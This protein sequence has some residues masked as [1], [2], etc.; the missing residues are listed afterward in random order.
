MFKSTP[1]NKALAQKIFNDIVNLYKKHKFARV[2]ENV[3][4]NQDFLGGFLSMREQQSLNLMYSDCIY[5][6]IMSASKDND[7]DKLDYMLNIYAP[8]L[9]VHLPDKKRTEI[10]FLKEK[11]KISVLKNSAKDPNVN[12]NTKL[13]MSGVSLPSPS[14]S[15]RVINKRFVIGVIVVILILFAVFFTVRF[16][17]NK[18]NSD[19][20]GKT[21][22]VQR[23]ITSP[24]AINKK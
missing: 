17:V 14:R 15:E 16:F 20:Q 21:D 6:E 8:L 13:R 1:E 12:F 11:R 7:S 24:A 23:E 3:E 19:I 2:I 4:Q 9:E 5:N 10:A 22:V 18:N